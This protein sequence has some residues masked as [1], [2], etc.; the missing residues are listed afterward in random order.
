MINNYGRYI[1]TTAIEA[2]LFDDNCTYLFYF[3]YYTTC[4]L[5]SV[6]YKPRRTLI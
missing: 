1:I 3:K 2:Y 5:R 4:F 6:Y